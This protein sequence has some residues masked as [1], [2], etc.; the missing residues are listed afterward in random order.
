VVNQTR[1]ENP[2]SQEQGIIQKSTET[3][4]AKQPH[5][6]EDVWQR[7]RSQLTIK[8]PDK[9]AIAK[10]RKYYLSHP[11]FMV[12]IA[13]RAEPFLYYIVEEIE[14]RNM[15]VE[16]A[17]LPIVESSYLP[18]GVSNKSA[19]GLWQF[20]PVSAKRFNV[21]QNWWYDGRRDIVQSTRAALDY[22][23]FFHRTFDQD[24]LNAIA[25]FNSGE[26]RVGRAIAKNK[27]AN[28]ATDFWS[29]NLPAETTDFVP[30]LLAIS[31]ILQ[32]AAELNYI[33]TPIKNSPAVEIVNIEDQLDLTLAAQWANIEP[34]K[35]L[36]LNPG[37]NRWA[38][39]PNSHYQLMLPVVVAD[40]F[41]DKLATT[42]KKDWLRWQRYRV[43]SGDSLSV[44]ASEYATNVAS[45]KKLNHLNSDTIRIGQMLI[46]PLTKNDM[47]PWQLT[48]PNQKKLIY[49]VKS[50]DNLWDISRKYK[51]R[52]RDIVRWNK[53]AGNS[54][55]QP[56]QK[57]EILL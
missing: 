2:L 46:V 7:I 5:E 37:L 42:N 39:A 28:L 57:L 12:T 43:N 19:A 33:F 26:G 48:K 11:N 16:L 14:K 1:E 6:Y 4:I 21:E 30:K 23:Q 36:Q 3:R 24:W 55:L 47:H 17:L 50:G 54:L 8:A 34:E 45:I 56:K 22:F 49:T 40:S 18:Y 10:W 44:I 13:Q 52:V 41:K 35:L 20:M 38:T 53:L 31:D 15:P 32:H 51:V 25:A 27:K 29:L 9:P